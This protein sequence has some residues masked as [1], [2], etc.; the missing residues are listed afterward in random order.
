MPP[1]VYTGR[2]DPSQFFS[3]MFDPKSFINASRI[4]GAPELEQAMIECR[5]TSDREARRKAIGRALKIIHRHALYVPVILQ[6]DIA[7]MQPRVKG[8]KPNILGKPRF[9]NISLEG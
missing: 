2:T 4:W 7:A 8:Y 1:S 9:E 3:L 5:I 6:T